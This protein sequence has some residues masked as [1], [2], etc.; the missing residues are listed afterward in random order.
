[1]AHDSVTLADPSSL[2]VVDITGQ[3]LANPDL[4][5]ELYP[6]STFKMVSLNVESTAPQTV[7]DL[8]E[9]YKEFQ[10]QNTAL[11]KAR[12]EDVAQDEAYVAGELA[13]AEAKTAGQSAAAIA[14]VEAITKAEVAD[15][16]LLQL[17]A[18]TSQAVRRAKEGEV[19]SLKMTANEKARLAGRLEMPF[20]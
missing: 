6:D 1:V 10:T 16:E 14:A 7:K 13:K 18:E 5:V 3:L 8:G 12:R 20:P 11:R 4:Q 17:P 15:L 2:T 9:A 19:Q